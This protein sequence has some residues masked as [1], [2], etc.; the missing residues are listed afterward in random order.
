MRKELIKGNEAIVQAAIL[1]GCRAA[2]AVT[3]RIGSAVRCESEEG[4]G[5]STR[6]SALSVSVCLPYTG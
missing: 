6:W 5:P 4:S 2:T 3:L 1:G